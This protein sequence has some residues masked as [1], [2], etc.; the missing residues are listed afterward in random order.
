MVSESSSSSSSS[1]D[2]S[3]DTDTNSRKVA[4]RNGKRKAEVPSTAKK[5]KRRRKNSKSRQDPELRKLIDTVNSIQNFLSHN[6]LYPPPSCPNQGPHVDDDNVSLNVS[7]ELFSEDVNFDKSTVQSDSER[8]VNFSLNTVL[9]EPTIPKSSQEHLAHLKS[10]QHLDT[11]EWCDV[12]Y[13]DVQKSYCSTPG[14]VEL[15]CNEEIKPFDKYPQL[16]IAEKS[17]AAITQAL[18]KQKDAAQAGFDSLLTWVSKNPNELNPS[19]IKNKINEIFVEGSY[20]KI[21]GDLLQITCGHRADVIEQRRDGILRSV[22]DRFVRSNLRKIP[23]TCEYLFNKDIFSS[24]LEKAGGI[25]KVFWPIRNASQKSNWSAA[26]AVPS[27]S[28]MPAQGF[29]FQATKGKPTHGHVMQNPQMVW[30]VP[31]SYPAQGYHNHPVQGYHN[32]PAQGFAN[33][34]FPQNQDKLK[35]DHNRTSRQRSNFDDNKSQ[36]KNSQNKNF[37][38]KRKF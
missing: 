28:K 5:A 22:K 27:T 1:S 23:P 38:S 31:N 11:P 18:L 26:Q 17:Y 20:N 4:S 29:Q 36:P 30:S 8:H 25:T 2:S 21:S 9:K 37:R 16:C 10:V 33:R 19:S 13:S 12:R 35:Y 34:R 7:G 6:S 24:A 15:E 3:S 14:F 32:Y